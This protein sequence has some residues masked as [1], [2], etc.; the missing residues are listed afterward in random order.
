MAMI[1]VNDGCALTPEERRALDLVARSA[2]ARWRQRLRDA[3]A[4][5]T[6]SRLVGWDGP[7]EQLQRLRNRRGFDLSRYTPTI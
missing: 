3:W 7:I 4:A 2:G 6:L 1:A 5:G